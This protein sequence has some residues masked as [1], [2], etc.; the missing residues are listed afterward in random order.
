M[1]AFLMI[2][3]RFP[4]TFRRFP[5]IFQIVPK[6]G[7]T[8]PNIFREFPKNSEDCRRLPSTFEEDPKM[9]R[10]YT[11]EFKHNLRDKPDVSEIIDIFTYKKCCMFTC[12]QIPHFSVV[13]FL[14]KHCRNM[15]F[16][17]MWVYLRKNKGQ[18]LKNF[19]KFKASPPPPKKN[20][21]F[22]TPPLKK[23]SILISLTWR[24]H[25]KPGRGTFPRNAQFRPLDSP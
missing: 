17:L 13:E 12:V 5:K 7:R 1:T 3:R 22:F 24:G 15:G 4:T 6:T 19:V 21:F 25:L 14:V 20:A 18:P 9:F 16:P 8:F 10:W 11:N 2:F 23:S